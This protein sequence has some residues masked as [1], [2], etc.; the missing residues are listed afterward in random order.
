MPRTSGTS[1]ETDDATPWPAALLSPSAVP[2]LFAALAARA[3]VVAVDRFYTTVEQI[4][5]RATVGWRDSTLMKEKR[6]LMTCRSAAPRSPL[7]DSQR[8]VA[9]NRQIAVFCQERPA[10]LPRSFGFDWCSRPV[11]LD[12][13]RRFQDLKHER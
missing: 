3:T 5:E 6:F 8:G 10:R 7:S 4:R 11:F 12:G 2:E 1:S 9:G 13:L